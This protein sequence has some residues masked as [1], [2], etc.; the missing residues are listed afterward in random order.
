VREGVVRLLSNDP[1]TPV[2]RRRWHFERVV[3]VLALLTEQLVFGVA[4]GGE[5]VAPLAVLNRGG[6]KLVV[7][8]FD[9]SGQL[10]FG[11]ERLVV[12]AGQV[13]RTQVR[14]A[15]S[16]GS[17]QVALTSNDPARRQVSLPW[18]AEAPLEVV[19]AEPSSGAVGVS[20]QTTVRLIFSRP[21]RQV[22]K[23]LVGLQAHILPEPQNAWRRQLEVEGTAVAI[24][25]ELAAAQ[26]YRLVVVQAEGEGGERLARPFEVQFSTAAQAPQAGGIAGTVFFEDGSAVV[27]AVFLAD[28][29]QALVGSTG[30]NGDGSFTLSQVAAGRYN[31][32]AQEEGT[33]VSVAYEGNVEVQ[34]GQTTSGVELIFPVQQEVAEEVVVLEEEVEVEEEPQLLA[35]STFAVPIRTEGIADLTGFAITVSFN[36]EAVELLEAAPD[37]PQ[38]KNVLYSAG[39]FPLFLMRVIDAGSV[40]YG[41]SLLAAKANRSPDSGG[42]L[43]YFTFR[44]L[45]TDAEVEIV[46]I[47]RRT[48]HGEDIVGGGKVRPS[49]G[50]G[51]DFD[52]NGAVDF[53]DFFLFADSFGRVAQGDAAR[54]DL[55]GSG[56]VDFGDFFIFA[57]AFGKSG[58]AVGKLLALAEEYLGLPASYELSPAYPNPF[59]AETLIRYQ[60][61]A[62]APVRL[63]VYDV[64]GQKVRILVDQVQEGGIHQVRWDGRDSQ[65]N[66]VGS[67]VYL[68]RLEAG[69]FSAVRKL[70][71]VR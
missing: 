3:P 66:P 11:K 39:G 46:Q 16:G 5:R 44:A 9:D 32:F 54:F 17:G 1:Q 28:E 12:E 61:P 48:L 15:G 64:L 23:G 36:P 25:L 37:S 45:R 38:E 70:A 68:Y 27:G 34:A 8:L 43:A 19:G 53:G 22:S 58:G 60:L 10:R 50:R 59:N 24:P 65:E 29:S 14:Y 13:E 62:M 21:L 35:D 42:L 41:G 31:L 30:I 18:Q 69:T 4:E 2:V 52:G 26:S 56:A 63:V 7:E 57:D 49:K 20:Q 71:L 67:G 40:E 51:A 55:D 33:G 47:R 6:G